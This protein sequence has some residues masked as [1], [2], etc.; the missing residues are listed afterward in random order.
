MDVANPACKISLFDINVVRSFYKSEKLNGSKENGLN[1]FRQASKTSS[2]KNGKYNIATRSREKQHQFEN[3]V[4]IVLILHLK[5]ISSAYLNWEKLSPCPSWDL[6]ECDLFQKAEVIV[7][8]SHDSLTRL[9]Q[10][11]VNGASFT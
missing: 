2:S 5:W 7:S 3:V 8:N 10:L 11:V 1:N 6:S 4:L 9:R